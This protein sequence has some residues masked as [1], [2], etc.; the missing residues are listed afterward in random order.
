MDL[1][2]S[3]FD[4]F[5]WLVFAVF[6]TCIFLIVKLYHRKYPGYPHLVALEEKRPYGV[7]STTQREGDVPAEG[8]P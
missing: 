8:V 5:C 4:P 7:P 3:P 6:L 2:Y 1:H